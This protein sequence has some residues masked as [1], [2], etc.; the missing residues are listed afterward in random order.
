MLAE[1][2]RPVSRIRDSSEIPVGPKVVISL[3]GV[4]RLRTG[5]VWVYR[6]D[7]QSAQDVAPG[8]LVS[9]ADERGRFF[10]S[11]LYSSSSQI[12]LR[13]LSAG[14][15]FDLHTL[16]RERIRA[17]LAYRER[18]ARDTDAC[19]LIFSE[20]DF[21]PGLIVD[22]YNEIL[23][24]QILTQAMDSESARATLISELSAGVKPVAIAERVEL[25]IRELEQ[26]TARAS[27]LL[28]G[29]KTST[30]FTMNGVQFHYDIGEGQKTGAFLDQRENYAAAARYGRGD[31]LDVFCY[32]G[33]FA[34]HLAKTC[35]HVTGVDSSRPAL[36][37][38][39]RNGVLN[40]QDIEWIEANAFDLLKDY[41]AAGR[42]YDVIVLDPPAFAKTRKNLETALRG[43]KELNLRALKMLRSGG[44]LVTC[45]CSYHVGEAD[46]LGVVI[47][48]GRDAHK[49][50]RLMERRGQ[51]QDHPILPSVPETSY[52][53]C[54]I[55]DVTDRK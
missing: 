15:V 39:D 21:L 42:L 31:A 13:M 1:R 54:L 3:R 30:I 24:L 20:A 37:V 27:G 6:S 38:A 47:E 41:S 22:R 23:A 50:L 2:P 16:L 36:E 28:L 18:I 4:N 17:A 45:S 12:A 44:T 14:A 49:I 48:A 35:G 19:R 7:I 26:L 46:F 9:V 43:Y 55:F 52:L 5:H 8:S 29:E 10:G 34:L 33:A 40:Q 51:A 25:H 11:A 53:K 32:Q